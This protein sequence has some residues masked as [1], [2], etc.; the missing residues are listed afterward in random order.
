MAGQP[1]SL[2][3]LARVH[4]ADPPPAAT[5]LTH[6]KLIVSQLPFPGI[7]LVHRLL[8]ERLVAST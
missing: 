2:Q 3:Y 7:S 4:L 6:T 5:F 8:N 1:G